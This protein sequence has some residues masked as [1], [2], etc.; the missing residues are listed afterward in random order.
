[1]ELENYYK[2]PYRTN[3]RLTKVSKFQF[4]VENFVRRNILSVE[5]FVPRK[6]CPIFQYKS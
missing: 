6:L 2:I 4:G 1:M 3:I 5:N